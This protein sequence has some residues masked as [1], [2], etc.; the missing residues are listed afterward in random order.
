[1]KR[2]LLALVALLFAI[3]AAYA[4]SNPCNINYCAIRAHYLSTASTNAT[5]VKGTAGAVYSIVAVNTT[6]TLYYLK[7]Y[8][9]AAAPTCA[10]STV[11]MTIPLP[12][13]ATGGTP[14]QVSPV[15]GIGFAN[16]IGLC[17][18]GGIADNDNTNAATGVAVN[19]VYR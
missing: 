3:P 1:M 15:F 11:V 10:S 8:D 14:V 17:I 13:S 7:F 19:I 2:A 18:T 12:A 16:G 5:S 9:L 6:A 4:Q